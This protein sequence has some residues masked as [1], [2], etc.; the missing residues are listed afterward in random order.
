MPARLPQ[1]EK[2]VWGD[3]PPTKVN[4]LQLNNHKFENEKLREVR[5]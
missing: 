1:A 4:M 3:L 5:L 2:G